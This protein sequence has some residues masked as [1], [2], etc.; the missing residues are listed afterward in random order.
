MK[1][2]ADKCHLLVIDQ[3]CV[4]QITV[5][6]ENSDVPNSSEE[7]LLKVHINSEP[8]FTSD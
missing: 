5:K 7:Q 4:D 1:I 8:S 6:I 3:R 2:N